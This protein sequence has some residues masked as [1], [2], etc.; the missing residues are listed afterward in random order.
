MN[1]LSSYY[2]VSAEQLKNLQSSAPTFK[3]MPDI[4]V[5]R[6][7][8]AVGQPSGHA[9]APSAST[10]A[11]GGGVP[12]HASAAASGGLV[13]RHGSSDVTVPTPH[14][15]DASHPVVPFATETVT[16]IDSVGTLPPPSTSALSGHTTP[17]TGIPDSGTGRS[18]AFGAPFGSPVLGGIAG[19]VAGRAGSGRSSLPTQGRTAASG[20]DF[21]ARGP[22]RAP[23]SRM[24]HTASMGH[25][26][27]RSTTPSSQISPVGRGVSGGTPR[28]GGT[29]TPRTGS[30]PATGTGRPRGVVG[31]RQS[32]VTG[33]PAKGGARLPRGTVVGG[34]EPTVSRSA[35]GRPGRG[36]V[37][38]SPTSG[39]RPASESGLR[40]R[41]AAT[42]AVTGTPAARTSAVRA[43]RNGMTRGGAGLVRG[44]GQQEKRGD[45][46]ERE[47]ARRPDRSIEGEGS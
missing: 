28:L 21:S 43:E 7:T 19:Y 40:G 11:G 33:T 26:A 31:G 37:F 10:A 44:R 25:P 38:G 36:G 13:E 12:G 42:E 2:S 46:R 14:I 34:E 4:G 23:V 20:G 27:V 18:N 6:P 1:R 15:S 39:G 41:A 9:L 30:D 24:G 5:P 22:E 47:E 45:R 29:T 8:V 35:T 3:D 17:V 16:H 32:A